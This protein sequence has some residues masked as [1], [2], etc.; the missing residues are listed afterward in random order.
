M[1]DVWIKFRNFGCFQRARQFLNLSCWHVSGSFP[2]FWNLKVLTALC[3]AVSYS[4]VV[5]VGKNNLI[6]KYTGAVT[7]DIGTKSVHTTACSCTASYMLS[8]PSSVTPKSLKEVPK[9]FV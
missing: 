8:C 2:D 4:C 9:T 6:K 7:V 1:S 5:V 3:V